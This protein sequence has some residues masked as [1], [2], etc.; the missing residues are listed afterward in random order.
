MKHV[1]FNSSVILNN[2]GFDEYTEDLYLKTPVGIKAVKV[3][4]KNQTTERVWHT[5]DLVPHNSDWGITY[6][7]ANWIPA[8]T[9]FEVIDWFE[10]HIGFVIQPTYDKEYKIWTFIIIPISTVAKQLWRKHINEGES[11][12]SFNTLEDCF[13]SAI[14]WICLIADEE[15]WAETLNNHIKDLA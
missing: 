5:G 13:S 8:P 2:L 1:D 4:S 10:K 12:L 3:D 11:Y 15:K 7:S 6:S 9:V 14:R